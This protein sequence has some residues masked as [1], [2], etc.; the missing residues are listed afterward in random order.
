MTSSAAC[1]S[2]SRLRSAGRLEI[3]RQLDVSGG[4][5]VEVGRAVPRDHR[6]PAA[7]GRRIAQ[8]L[9]PVP[10]RQEHVLHQV[11]HV[12]PRHPRQQQ[13]VHNPRVPIVQAA[14]SALVALARLADQPGVFGRMARVEP[15]RSRACGRQ[16]GRNAATSICSGGR[17][18]GRRR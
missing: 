9:E 1:A 13:P 3:V 2:A 7:E 8:G 5:A 11:V 16:D 4:A 10:G 18:V 15:C 12:L 17:S 6:E 14:E